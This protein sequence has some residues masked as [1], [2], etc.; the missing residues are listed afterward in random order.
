[1]T[2]GKNTHLPTKI[3]VGRGTR[4]GSDLRN[5]DFPEDKIPEGDYIHSKVR[6]DY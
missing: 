5:E 1:M 3:K 4:I 6:T 2:I